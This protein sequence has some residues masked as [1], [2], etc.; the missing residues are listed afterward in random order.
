MASSLQT[1]KARDIVG[2][3][4]RWA[5]SWTAE[6]WDNVGL[7]LGDPNAAVRRAWV[8][9]ELSPEL[10]ERAIAARVDMILT[11]HPPL[12]RPLKNLRQDNPATARLLRAAN[13]GV[14]LF[15]AHTNLDAAPGGVNDA[16]AARLDLVEAKPLAPAGMGG[17]QKL[18]CFAPQSHA[19][20]IAQALFAAGAGVIGDYAQCSFSAPGRGHFLA[21]DQGRPLVG[22]AGQAVTVEEI[23]LEVVVPAREAGAAVR[24]MLRAH[25]YEEPAF[26]IYPLRQGPSG[27][28]LGRVGQLAE[29]MAGERFAAWAARRLGA[30]TA[31]IAGPA[32]DIVHRVA[33]LGGSGAEYLAQAAAMGAQAFVTGE[34]GHHSAEQAQDLGL[35]LCCLGHYQTEVVIVEPWAKRLAAMLAEAGFDCEITASAQ[36]QGPWRPA[37]GPGARP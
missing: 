35:L 18:V 24:A 28:G 27:F 37:D 7:L 10:L 34:A 14:A 20:Q 29:P 31:M 1:P 21:P 13:A 30:S 8:A 11:H 4:E 26:D 15:A 12:F 17:L 16:L 25:P 2:L 9:L 36:G 23:R 33:V 5:P 3:M 22:Q 19:E 32:P 6:D